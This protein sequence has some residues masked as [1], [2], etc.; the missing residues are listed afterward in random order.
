MPLGKARV[1]REG[2]DLTIVTWGAIVYRSL[3]AARALE[4]EGVSVEVIDVRS[5]LPLDTETILASA[6][7]TGRVLVAYEDH[8]FMGFGAEIAA[9][10]SAAAF[11][12]LDA[13]VRRVA[14]A[15]SSIPYADV[16]EKE[17]LPQDENVLAA[18]REVLA[19]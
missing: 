13:P 3:A 12:H 14:G 6:R 10:V 9:Q 19:Y 16:L 5:M 7:K 2:T 17:V 8:E 18:A 11:G 1:A 4:R 15:F